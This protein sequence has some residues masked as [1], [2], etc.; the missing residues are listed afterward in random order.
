MVATA[1]DLEQVNELLDYGN[2]LTTEVIYQLFQRL[3]SE[4]PDYQEH[5]P[6]FSPALAESWSWSPDHLSL[7]FVLRD[8]LVWSDGAPIT[9]EDVRYT[10]QAQIDPDVAWFYSESKEQIRD[11]EVVDARTVRFHFTA[12]YARMFLDAVEGVILPHHAWSK[13]PFSE[14]RKQPDWFRQNLVVSGPFTLGTWQPQQQIELVRNPRASTTPHLDRIVFR[15]VPDK[16]A[17]LLQLE[18]G[19]LDFVLGVPAADR[20]RLGNNPKLRLVDVWTRQYEYLAWNTKDP[21]FS[22]PA[23]R[24]ALTQ[25]IDRQTLLATIWRGRGRVG[26]SPLLADTWATNRSLEPWPF[27]PA[28]ARAG[29]AAAGWSDS[30][31]DGILDRGGQPFRFELVTNT[32]NQTRADLQVAIQAMLRAVGVDMVPRLVEGATLTGD[33]V[34]HRFQATLGAW[35]IDTSMSV[36]AQFHSGEANGGYNFGSYTNPELDRLIEQ[37]EKVPE[38]ADMKPLLDTIQQILHQEQPY[39]FLSEPLRTHGTSARL[40]EVSPSA[41]F[42]FGNLERWWIAP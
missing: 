20:E 2:D 38:Q 42:V 36:R 6:T 24:R 37:A 19:E 12:V 4:N 9:A 22:D 35:A 23:V 27:D 29:L 32:G 39:T 15:V 21:L 34:A 41:L 25:A 31:G 5:P 16:A 26:F 11:V 3:V 33:L 18:S 40:R 7:T 14:W 30:N 28:A 1:V 17:Q 13:L 10:W 8:G